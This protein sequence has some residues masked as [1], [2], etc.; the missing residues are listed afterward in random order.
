MKGVRKLEL[1]R[2]VGTPDGS[3]PAYYRMA[4][5]YFDDAAHMKQVMDTPEAKATVADLANFATGGVTVLVS[6]VS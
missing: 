3:S 1:S 4:D 5:L 6:D 2:V